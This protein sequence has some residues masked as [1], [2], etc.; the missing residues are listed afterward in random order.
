VISLGSAPVAFLT[1]G[2]GGTRELRHCWQAVLA[3]GGEPIRVAVSR[4]GPE[5]GTRPFAPEVGRAEVQVTGASPGDYAGLVLI[6]PYDAGEDASSPDMLQFI[7]GFFDFGLPVAASCRAALDLARAD[8]IRGRT[9]TSEPDLRPQ[10][11]AAGGAWIDR[12]VARCGSG[13][14]TLITASTPVSLPAF[15]DQFTRTFAAA[16]RAARLAAPPGA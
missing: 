3:R 8:V 7:A 10:V 9:V 15:C 6:R 12:P 1:A 14:A 5:P 11:T 4:A 13:A 16:G 2:A